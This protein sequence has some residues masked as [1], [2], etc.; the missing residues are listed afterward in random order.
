[1]EEVPRL[2]GSLVD[3]A[4][5]AKL[6]WRIEQQQHWRQAPAVQEGR[7]PS[8]DPDME[9]LVSVGDRLRVYTERRSSEGVLRLCKRLVDG[10]WE[11]GTLEPDFD[12]SGL[13]NR[14]A[15]EQVL[16]DADAAEHMAV[17]QEARERAAATR[18][19]AEQAGQQP[20]AAPERQQ[21]AASA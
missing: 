14:D 20:P 3:A 13:A 16:A 8:V 5:A 7:Q 21:V 9:E 6:R 11:N 10:V 18:A 2:K 15:S 12:L 17:E 1:M 19:E 4:G